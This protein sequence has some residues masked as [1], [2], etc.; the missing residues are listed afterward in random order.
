KRNNA[1]I[2]LEVA[3]QARDLLGANG[4]VDEYPIMRHLANLETVNTYEGTHNVH[5]LL[6][7]QQITGLSA[8]G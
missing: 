2:A 1:Q 4:I 6:L 3:R 7:G 8:F 5:T